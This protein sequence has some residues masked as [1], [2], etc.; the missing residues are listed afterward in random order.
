[1]DQKYVEM[2][3]QVFM[4][5]WIHFWIGLKAK[6]NLD[7]ENK[8]RNEGKHIRCQLL[9]EIYVDSVQC[10][11]VWPDMFPFGRYSQ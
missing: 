10:L 7:M 6:W 3:N 11:K 2:A 5:E 4:Q 8:E 1:M 9:Q